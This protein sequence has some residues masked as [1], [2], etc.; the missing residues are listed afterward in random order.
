MRMA[1]PDAANQ[2][3]DAIEA[4]RRDEYSMLQ[5]QTPM[6]HPEKKSLLLMPDLRFRISRSRRSDS[7]LQ[8]SYG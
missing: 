1:M 7:L 3:N 8:V 6:R 2:Y 5:G 4:L